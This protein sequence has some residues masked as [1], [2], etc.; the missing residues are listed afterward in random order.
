MAKPKPWYKDPAKLDDEDSRPVP[1]T[2]AVKVDYP[3]YMKAAM[4]KRAE[5]QAKG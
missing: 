5:A 2:N 1:A 3:D 4:A